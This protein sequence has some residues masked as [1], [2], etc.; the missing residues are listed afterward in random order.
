VD[1]GPPV[2]AAQDPPRQPRVLPAPEAPRL[3]DQDPTKC[4]YHH[5][6]LMFNTT[7]FCIHYL[8]LTYIFSILDSPVMVSD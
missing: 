6:I 1:S 2:A 3:A 5:V 4:M 8:V 7:M